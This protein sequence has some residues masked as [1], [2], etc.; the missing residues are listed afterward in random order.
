MITH[1]LS[2]AARIQFRLSCR[3]FA[4]AKQLSLARTPCACQT[5]PLLYES[6]LRGCAPRVGLWDVGLCTFAKVCGWCVY[7]T[8]LRPLVCKTCGQMRRAGAELE[9]SHASLK[10]NCPLLLITRNRGIAPTLIILCILNSPLEF[11]C[12]MQ[13]FKVL[14][15]RTQES[16]VGVSN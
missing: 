6:K 8:S 10:I 12:F 2:L 11:A 14:L 16:R 13:K 15:I 4:L 9:L 1:T 7:A 5:P 3:F